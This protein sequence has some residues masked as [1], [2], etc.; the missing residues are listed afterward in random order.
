MGRTRSEAGPAREV[1]PGAPRR[2]ERLPL[3][4]AAGPPALPPLEDVRDAGVDELG[5]AA[6]RVRR[7][8]SVDGAAPAPMPRAAAPGPLRRLLRSRQTLRQA[9]VLTEVI[10][11]PSA[12]KRPSSA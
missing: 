4:V 1:R 9:I 12:L 10:G 7:A 3:E 11:P 2:A 8:G 6:P 5:T